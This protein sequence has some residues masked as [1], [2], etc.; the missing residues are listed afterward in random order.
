MGPQYIIIC[1]PD[2]S[3]YILKKFHGKLEQEEGMTVEVWEGQQRLQAK[4]Y[5]KITLT[6]HLELMTGW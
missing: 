3:Q 5:T 4:L 2:R 6:I 1:P